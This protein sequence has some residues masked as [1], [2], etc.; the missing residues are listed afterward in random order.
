MALSV[1]SRSE[2][3]HVFALAAGAFFFTATALPPDFAAAPAFAGFEPSEA[4]GAAFAT[5]LRANVR[6]RAGT[7]NRVDLFISGFI[8]L[9]PPKAEYVQSLG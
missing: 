3:E 8:N 6:T 7:I 5:G 4:L 2:T 9:L 1:P